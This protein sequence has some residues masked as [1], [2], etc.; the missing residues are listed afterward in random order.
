MPLHLNLDVDFTD[1]SLVCDLEDGMSVSSLGSMSS[2]DDDDESDSEDEDDHDREYPAQYKRRKHRTR[3]KRSPVGFKFEE[4]L[5]CSAPDLNSFQRTMPPRQVQRESERGKARWS[6]DFTKSFSDLHVNKTSKKVRKTRS[7]DD[8]AAPDGTMDR[9]APASMSGRQL[10]QAKHHLKHSEDKTNDRW[11]PTPSHQDLPG[12]SSH[13]PLDHTP[14]NPRASM[15]SLLSGHS[16]IG[17]VV[18]TANAQW[19]AA[20]PSGKSPLA[21]W[22]LR[23]DY[24]VRPSGRRSRACSKLSAPDLL[25]LGPNRDGQPRSSRSKLTL[26]LLPESPIRGL[27][28]WNSS[29]SSFNHTPRVLSMISNADWSIQ[30][31]MRKR[32]SRKVS[33]KKKA[34]EATKAAPVVTDGSDDS[35]E[36]TEEPILERAPSL[37]GIRF[38]SLDL[39]EEALSSE[40]EDELGDSSQSEMDGYQQDM[41]GYEQAQKADLR[42]NHLVAL[43]ED[44]S[45]EDQRPFPNN[46]FSDRCETITEEAMDHEDACLL[47]PPFVQKVSDSMIRPPKRRKSDASNT[48]LLCEDSDASSTVHGVVLDSVIRKDITHVHP[49]PR[50]PRKP[51][52]R[53]S[54]LDISVTSTSS[55]ESSRRECTRGEKN[56]KTPLQKWS[57]RKLKRG[58]SMDEKQPVLPDHPL[59]V[60]EK[61]PFSMSFNKPKAKTAAAVM[62]NN[63]K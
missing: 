42:G 8:K 49:S 34:T 57:P 37:D 48:S 54:L 46:Y 12:F 38:P 17:G 13:T 59:L 40:D 47:A 15:P 53:H 39:D 3:G 60:D 24:R 35:T 51:R 26:G 6:S 11:S 19:K 21:S 27:S 29:S 10:Q 33:I 32:R 7:L 30:P 16:Q 44:E 22:L 50:C 1:Q 63:N 45:F 2:F 56:Q 62:N 14:R 23:D 5:L 25:I 31:R 4:S 20:S 52:R 28:R 61:H 43:L 36:K 55:C 18:S 9:W 41:N 58:L